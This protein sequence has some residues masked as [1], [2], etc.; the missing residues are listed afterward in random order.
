MTLLARGSVLVAAA[1]EA[2][3]AL[4]AG[5]A[6]WADRCTRG[7]RERGWC[8]ARPYG[9]AERLG[10]EAFFSLSSFLFYFSFLFHYLNSNLV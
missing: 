5:P 8:G 4:V 9:R 1:S 10:Y 6:S 7:G 3:A 2:R